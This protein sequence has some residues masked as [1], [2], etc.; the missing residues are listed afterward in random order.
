[1]SIPGGANMLFLGGS[2][3]TAYQINQSLRFNAAT[4][5]G[6]TRSPSSNGNGQTWTWS[7]WVKKG[8]HNHNT[9]GADGLL[10]AGTNSFSFNFSPNNDGLYFVQ[11]SGARP[12]EASLKKWRDP[13]AWLHI[14]L[15]ADTTNSN[16]SDRMRVYVNG[17]R[18]TDWNP[19]NSNIANQ[20]QTLQINQTSQQQIGCHRDNNGITYEFYGYMAEVHMIDGT[21]KN[22]TD[23]GEYDDNG[24]WRPIE[25]TGGG[26]GTNGYYMKFDPSASN[27]IGHDHSGQGNHY[28]ASGFTTSGTGTDVMSD[29]P[30]NNFCTL[31]PL[32]RANINLSTITDGNLAYRANNAV[33]GTM[34]LKSGKWYWEF[35]QDYRQYGSAY[36]MV[37]VF[38]CYPAAF[39]DGQARGDTAA[40]YVYKSDGN[41]RN[42]G[43]S[44][45]YG[46]SWT[47]GDTIGV[48]LDMD[49][50]TLTFYKNNSSQ[51]QA[52][53]G[54]S[55]PV[56]PEL[57]ATGGDI[58]GNIN[59]G[60]RAFTYTPP[61]G[62]KSVCTAN[63][64]TP[65]LTNG[66]EYVN[67]VLY[68]GN[69]STK[70]VSG[71]G[72]QPDFVW[73]KNRTAARNH[74]LFD[75]V[76]GAGKTLY[77]NLTDAESTNQSG[78]Y[79][80][81]FDSDGFT[82]TGGVGDVNAADPYVSW[83]WKKGS[84]PGFNIITYSGN[85]SSS[86]AI[87]HGL[88]VAPQM[89]ITKVR[90]GA[91]NEGWPVW[92]T[93]LSQAQSYL[94]L[95][96][97]DGQNNDSNIYGGSSNQLPTSTNYYVGAG[98]VTNTSGRTYVSYVFAPVDGFSAFGKYIGNGVGY[99]GA[100]IWT[101]FRPAIFMIKGKDNN[102]TAWY[103]HDSTRGE[104]NPNDFTLSPD[105]T[106][107]EQTPNDVE[108]DMCAN[109]FRYSGSNGGISD[110]N[111]SGREFIWAAWAENPFGGDGVS[112][113]CAR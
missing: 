11:N 10:G 20:N 42:N 3:D 85:G 113:A 107:T 18:H 61:S 7:A 19:G 9:S 23:F 48:A 35:T 104:Y 24:V 27:G 45:S 4:G 52:F 58:G 6:L 44:S 47:T 110:R 100:F 98:G 105:Q 101:G 99:E 63:L 22:P 62:Y 53:S 33:V 97:S 108:W 37:G 8:K 54:I 80:S 87:A 89:I 60:Q 5:T 86:R 66:N 112:P 49:N 57:S 1:M 95:N 39:R 111:Q 78:G 25:Y 96:R 71:V 46:A 75:S 50:G 16:G 70:S 41:K 43:S 74:Q 55:G 65:G 2:A 31:N 72:F 38:D 109:G 28:T 51:G 88:G 93:S 69:G 32:I 106:Y 15:V 17:E 94:Q 84:T 40:S 77:S 14:V 21:A 83:N 59:F 36:G 90:T 92:H 82:V 91:S 73:I 79:L 12:Q 103:L 26:Y 30:T 29:T 13:S 64:P 76:R 81:S 56:V 68:T 67:T 34:L 102:S